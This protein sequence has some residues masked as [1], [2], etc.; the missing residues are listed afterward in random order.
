MNK[1]NG[2]YQTFLALGNSGRQEDIDTLMNALSTKSDLATTRLV[3]FA[4]SL[5]DTKEGSHRIKQILFHGSPKQRN[6]A[7]LYFK[8]KGNTT[9]LDQ[10]IA[11]GK[12]DAQQAYSK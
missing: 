8:R 9:L 6:Y 1:P 5:V 7:A 10:A 2:R 11:E 12:I 3:D 4:L